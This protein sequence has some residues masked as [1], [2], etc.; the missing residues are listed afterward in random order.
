VELAKK[1][2]ALVS[3]VSARFI[4]LFSQCL[5]DA[6]FIRTIAPQPSLILYPSTNNTLSS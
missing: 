4:S 1:G 5:F 2:L 6:F 3:D